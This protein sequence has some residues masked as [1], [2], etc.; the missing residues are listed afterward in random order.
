[1]LN[2]QLGYIALFSALFISSIA[3]YFSVAGLA[4]IFSAYAISIIIMG[5]SIELGKLVAV[6]WLHYNWKDPNKVLKNGLSFFVI[7]TMFIT[8]MGIFGYLSKSHVEQT[9]Q[10]QESVA[11]VGRINSEIARNNAIIARSDQKITSYENN[12]SGV[13]ASLNSQIDKEQK[14]I[15]SAYDRVK[16]VIQVQ[17]DII[18]TDETKTAS[19][20]KPYTSELDG[21]NKQLGDLQ[22]ALSDRKIKIAQ[23]IVGTRPDGSYREKTQAAIRDFRTRKETRRNELLQKIDSIRGVPSVAVKAAQQEINR[24]RAS[25]Q[26]EI[27]ESNA[28]IK[29]LRSRMGKSN[30]NDIE[31]LIT[32][33]RDKSKVANNELDTL[34][35]EK[36]KLEASTRKLEAEVG[37]IKYI[38][39][40]AYGRKA[41]ADLLEKAVQWLIIIII[42]VFD[43]F[44]IF[45]LIAAQHS[46]DRHREENPVRKK[47]V[48]GNPTPA[49]DAAPREYVEQQWTTNDEGVDRP[50]SAALRDHGGY[51]PTHGELDDNDPP[52]EDG[53]SVIL[54]ELEFEDV[55]EGI[56]EF[57]LETQT[58]EPWKDLNEL[59]QIAKDM[60]L[61]PY[62]GA[63][64][65]AM[66]K[67]GEDYINFNGKVYRTEALTQMF[68]GLG[69]NFNKTVKSGTEFPPPNR[70]G[71]MFI[72]TDLE[73]TQLYIF[74][75]NDWDKI[76]K[77]IL[78]FGA[79][80]HEYTKALIKRVG[81][82]E[83]NPELLNEAE[84]KHIEELLSR[85]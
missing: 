8:S 76:D 74:N 43:P 17:I 49:E 10:S 19:R 57:D 37:P 56:E 54:D 30:A 59:S 3:I 24:I 7:G 14:R 16:P 23:G 66:A 50:F 77:N 4:A 70:V 40:F 61:P 60:N 47:R 67:V 35:Q 18:A 21:I 41:D 9:A 12:G 31:T 20:S 81:N 13:D 29:S 25:V 85:E 75:G 34:T 28:T 83:Y 55:A 26:S 80:S 46:F 5:T 65:I 62:S 32:V 38:A 11:Q 52:Q 2:K 71:M 33:E 63:G 72:R 78:N 51:Q 42:F 22:A 36:Y 69:F 27:D 82:G 84:K 44:A 39:E 73:P 64:K 15:D 79:Y 58:E 6:V 48:L 45:L 1:M 53:D 68:P